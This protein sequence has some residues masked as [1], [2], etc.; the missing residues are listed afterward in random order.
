MATIA[1]NPKAVSATKLEQE[2]KEMDAGVLKDIPAKTSLTL[3]GK[4]M[5]GAQ[6]DTQIQQYLE[7]IDAADAAKAQYQ[8]AVVARRG[9][10]VEARDFFLQLKKAVIAYFG[11]QSPQLVDFGLTPAKPKAAKTSAEQA[12]IEAKKT[13]T[14][15]ARGTQSKK[16]KAQIQPGVATPA[17]MIGPDGKPVVIPGTAQNASLPTVDGTATPSPAASSAPPPSTGTSAPVVPA[18]SSP[19]S[20][21]T[22]S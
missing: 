18:G 3:N 11:T 5:T 22:Q 17:V 21:T 15:K 16:A 4:A 20:T 13:Q 19:G 12:V 2:L 6:I 7:T 1:S 14:K 9:E 10:A 8:T